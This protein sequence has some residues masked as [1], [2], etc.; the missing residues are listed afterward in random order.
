MSDTDAFRDGD[1]HLS[2]LVTHPSFPETVWFV[3][4]Q[5]ARVEYRLRYDPTTNSFSPTATRSL[6]YVRGFPGA[7][8]WV[9]G[10]G[11]PPGRHCDAVLVTDA[12]L[13]AGV[14]LAASVCGLFHRADGDHKI[15]LADPHCIAPETSVEIGELPWR[16]LDA[17]RR[18]QSPQ[19]E[20]EGW[21]SRGEAIEYLRRFGNAATE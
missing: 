18:Y 8:G 1:R 10:L 11:T 19:R 20:G 4:E 2:R 21:R 16:L 17:L 3:V 12:E 6:G 15:I 13:L 5:P 14:V 7:Y 9:G